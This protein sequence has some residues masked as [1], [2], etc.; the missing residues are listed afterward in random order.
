MSPTKTDSRFVSRKFRAWRPS[1]VAASTRTAPAH[2]SSAPGNGKPTPPRTAKKDKKI[3]ASP[4]HDMTLSVRV[5][6]PRRPP[7]H[8][9]RA[10]KPSSQPRVKLEKYAY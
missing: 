5:E 10:P 8:A 4:V 1:E 3:R 7:T 9:S 2:G 6:A